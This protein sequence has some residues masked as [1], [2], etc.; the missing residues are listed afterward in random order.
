MYRARRTAAR[1]RLHSAA[2]FAI[3]CRTSGGA[4]EGLVYQRGTVGLAA[5]RVWWPQGA[6]AGIPV[7]IYAQGCA[8]PPPSPPS[9]P[10]PP[11]AAATFNADGPS[12]WPARYATAMLRWAA[13]GCSSVVALWCYAWHLS[14]AAWNKI[15][16]AL[17]GNGAPTSTH[18][19][20]L[21]A[22]HSVPASTHA[23]Q[24]VYV[25]V[26][27]YFWGLSHAAQNAIHHALHGN[28]FD[29]PHDGDTDAPA[30]APEQLPVFEWLEWAD[31]DPH[32]GSVT[33]PQVVAADAT[34]AAAAAHAAAMFSPEGDELPDVD[35]NGNKTWP[36]ETAL[37]AAD[38]AAATK[39]AYMAG[40]AATAAAAADARAA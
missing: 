9:S 29:L 27:P 1:G 5:R 30:E 28:G 10:R 40:L 33:W 32:P 26:P 2:L 35:Q 8:T 7:A 17:F 24:H 4:H 20:L 34:A 15:L 3:C 16:H 6:D 36:Q 18:H 14:H 21:D 23:T 19:D 31:P 38:A 13:C 12:C 25:D 22:Y 11:R 37:I 39:A